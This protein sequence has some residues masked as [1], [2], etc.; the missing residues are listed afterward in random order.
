VRFRHADYRPL[1]LAFLPDG[2][3]LVGTG[4][5][6]V[7]W[8]W[9]AETGRPVR[10]IR[11][12]LTIRAFAV[13]N[14]GKQI[15]LGGFLP[16][17]AE[18]PLTAAAVVID[19][20]TGEERRRFP[21]EVWYAHFVVAFTPDARLLASVDDRGVLR[22][23]EIGSGVEILRQQFPGGIEPDLAIS[24]DGATMG[25]VCGAIG[26]LFSWRWQ[27]GEEP[28][29]LKRAD[30]QARRCALSADGKLLAVCG[31]IPS[32]VHLWNVETAKHLRPL[33]V[34]DAEH[35]IA[36][37]LLFTPDGR[38][39]AS[40]SRGGQSWRHIVH[41]WDP[42]T[43]GRKSRF[44][45]GIEGAECLAVSPD[46]RL[47]A[48]A[49]KTL[50][51]WQLESGKEMSANDEAHF[52]HVERIACFGDTIVTASHDHTV[53]IWDASTG[54]QRHRFTHGGTVRGL[55][56]SPDGARI[57]SSSMDDSVCVWNARTGQQM[58]KFAGHGKVGG[59]RPL[60]FTPDGKRLLS[61]GDDCFLRVWDLD[62]GKPI[63]E[64]AVPP[65]AASVGDER[66]EALKR[67]AALRFAHGVL[68]PDGAR[69]VVST[70]RGLSVFDAS[71]GR[72][73][74]QIPT[75]TGRVMSMA[76]SPDS[77]VLLV[78]AGG[79]PVETKLADGRVNTSTAKNHSICLWELSSGKLMRQIQLPDGGAGPVAFSRDGKTFA[80]AVSEPK[81]S[82][83][84]WDL[85]TGEELPVITDF[86][87]QV[88]ALSFSPDGRRLVAGMR[89]TTALV[90]Q[91]DKD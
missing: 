75:D 29:E 39:L 50:R 37:D 15:A 70:A 34:P 47:L 19:T 12:P 59:N 73:V 65:T 54:R 7:I 64:H 87:V 61:W 30:F 66:A 60:M 27:A 18:K 44:D 21:R 53:R 31:D 20:A 2:K 91:L 72:E 43:A 38:Y 68:T 79:K 40:S 33:E 85:K 71:N 13:S 25:V 42:T 23:E 52:G 82:I 16:R 57:A 88:S 28:R 62:N 35:T 5:G 84:R 8:F 89:D 63:I 36:R 4:D 6:N 17:E 77:G 58:Y 24:A 69:L 9:D 32:T 10:Q 80:A 81:P 3:T 74:R 11:P 49:G 46:A 67:L 41:L 14:N 83:R 78:S 90:W 86:D 1:G 48:A 22:I 45:A 51:V 56:V 26:R 76:V 55:A